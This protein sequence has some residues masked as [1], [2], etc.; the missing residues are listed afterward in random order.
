[1]QGK[2]VVRVK[3]KTTSVLRTMESTNQVKA[4]NPIRSVVRTSGKLHR[5]LLHAG[6]NP[7]QTFLDKHEASEATCKLEQNLTHSSVYVISDRH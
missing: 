1:M 7:A 6:E 3:S 4:E 5:Q 2:P